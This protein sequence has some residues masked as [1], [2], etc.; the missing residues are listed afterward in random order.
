MD[1]RNRNIM[2]LGV[3]TILGAVGFV[4]A[5]YYLLG[6]PVLRGGMDVLVALQDGGGLKRG[7]RVRLQG[8]DVGS[9]R[10]VRLDERTGVL[11]EIRLRDDIVLSADSR[12]SVM[13]DVFGAHSTE[14]TQGVSPVKLEENDT[15]RGAS[16]PAP[17]E[18]AAGLGAQA[19]S[20]LS[21]ADSLLSPETIADVRATAAVLPSGAQE[22]RAAFTELRLAA[23]AFRR[24]AENV[25]SARAGEL[26]TGAVAEVERG[27][28]AL[29]AAANA[30]ERSIGS[31]ESVLTKID[32]GN[33]TLARLVNDSSLYLQFNETMREM[34]ALATDIRER[35]GRYINIK[36]F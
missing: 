19:R 24:T 7:D 6:T 10:G 23:A 16:A 35:P 26:A 9:V 3:L 14:L 32:R 15:I 27:A 21:S 31:L 4:A 8:V 13:G 2:A 17:L 28:R 12:A 11:A 22:L 33:G 36:I 29:T 30:M 18:M 1:K 20:I 5:L 25:E 34:G